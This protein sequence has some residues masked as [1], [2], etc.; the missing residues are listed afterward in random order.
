MLVKCNKNV[1]LSS[2]D[3]INRRKGVFMIDFLAGK[4]YFSLNVKLESRSRIAFIPYLAYL[5]V[6]LVR[7]QSQILSKFHAIFMCL[8]Y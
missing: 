6:K 2:D 7:S 1:Q 8:D 5:D 3:F 4:S